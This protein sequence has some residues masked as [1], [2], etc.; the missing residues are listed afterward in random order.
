M[1]KC[2]TLQALKVNISMPHKEITSL[3]HTVNGMIAPVNLLIYRNVPWDLGSK[4]PIF[5][6]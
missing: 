6:A 3:G 4:N 1:K 5:F 2:H